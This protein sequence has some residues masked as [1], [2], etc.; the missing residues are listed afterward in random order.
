MRVH[1]ARFFLLGFLLLSGA[2]STAPEVPRPAIETLYPADTLA[3]QGFNIQADGSAALAMK[4]RNASAASVIVWEGTR[5]VT[6]FGGPTTISGTVPKDLFARRG[7]YRI[8]IL[9]TKTNAK[10]DPATFEVK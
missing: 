7:K 1:Y 5:L 2:C 9:D 10:S 4:C 8:E 6:A 3:G